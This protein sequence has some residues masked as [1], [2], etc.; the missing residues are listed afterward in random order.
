MGELA[1]R[2]LSAESRFYTGP[3]KWLVASSPADL[4]GTVSPDNLTVLE[5][6][7][8]CE[9]WINTARNPDPRR[10]SL[11]SAAHEW[12]EWL[13]KVDRL[14]VVGVHL[15]SPR[16]AEDLLSFVVE[17]AAK[18]GIE[19]IIGADRLVDQLDRE[20]FT[21]PEF[22]YAYSLERLL[23][24]LRGEQPGSTTRRALAPMDFVPDRAQKEAVEAKSGVVQIIAPAGSGKTAVLIERIREL[25]RRGAS[26]SKILAVTFNVGAREELESRLATADV[27]GV[28]VANFHRL[29]CRILADARKLPRDWRRWSASQGQLRWLASKAKGAAGEHGVWLDPPEAQSGLSDIKLGK[30][31]TASEYAASLTGT[32]DDR[33][34]TLAALYTAY[35]ELKRTEGGNPDFDDMIMRAVLLLRTDPAVRDRWQHKCEH[36]L[37]DEYQDIEWSQELLVRIIAAPHDQLLCVGD[38]DQTLYSFRRASVR[39]IIDLD[40]LYPGLQRVALKINY[41]CPRDVVFASGTLINHNGVRFPKDIL[42]FHEEHPGSAVTLRPLSTQE[43]GVVTAQQLKG[44]QRGEVAVLARTTDALRPAA[45]ACADPDFKVPID[46]PDKL[47]APT[48]AR[49]ALEDH[50]RLAFNPHE[51]DAKLI[52]RVCQKPSR[53]A[54]ST[55]MQRA[56]ELLKADSSFELAFEDVAPPTRARGK[57]WAPGELFMAVSECSDAAKAI[58]LLRKVGGL[59]EWF[60]DAEKMG[61]LDEFE[62]EVLEQAQ[63]DAAGMTPA[64]YLQVLH[65]QRNALKATRDPENGI[66]FSTIHRAKGRQW[67]HVI[68]LACEKD[69]LP[70][71]RSLTVTQEALERGEGIEAERRLAYVAFT[72]ATQKLEIHYDKARPSQFLT[73][74]GLLATAAQRPARK[75]PPPPGFSEPDPPPRPAPGRSLRAIIKRLVDPGSG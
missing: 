69:T 34:H 18:R 38:E 55:Q 58:D 3:A 22:G 59:D 53:S 1:E 20:T 29:G 7:D 44:C 75:P 47:F 52:K 64:A 31:Q 45:L 19:L 60:Q 2:G 4:N 66:E 8:L 17:P 71:K 6:R 41:R 39:R 21:E 35:E 68:L 15:D 32:S 13:A 24:S 54:S 70:H 42:P 46:G 36:V 50:L 12:F 43:S 9:R 27:A 74:A 16:A 11:F 65:A 40:L 63:R 25:L 28:Q 62:Y 61:G 5:W 37:V 33:E 72:R 23:W 51:A 57:L 67:P 14:A 10:T 49:R 26:P 56:L 73:E 30:L 48:G